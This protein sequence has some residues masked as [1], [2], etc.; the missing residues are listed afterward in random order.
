MASQIRWATC[1]LRVQDDPVSVSLALVA[2]STSRYRCPSG[3]AGMAP[4]NWV[5]SNAARSLKANA[6]GT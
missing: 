6:S 1:R 2:L 4:I 5:S 3:P